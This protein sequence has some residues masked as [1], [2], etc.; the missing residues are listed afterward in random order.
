MQQPKNP[1]LGPDGTEIPDVTERDRA[2]KTRDAYG[3]DA[4]GNETYGPDGR[5]IDERYGRDVMTGGEG[6]VA[7]HE[8]GGPDDPP[9]GAPATDV[10]TEAPL[11]AG[12]PPSTP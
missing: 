1:E 7:D 10:P 4:S 2:V 12:E 5:R 3:R 11:P 9:A 8:P 6:D